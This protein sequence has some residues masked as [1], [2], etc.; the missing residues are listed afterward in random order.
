M[1]LSRFRKILLRT[2]FARSEALLR[3][4]GAVL[5]RKIAGRTDLVVLITCL[6]N[7]RARL[8]GMA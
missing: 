1:A 4:N 8:P 2:T 5:P 6:F 7:K 3:H